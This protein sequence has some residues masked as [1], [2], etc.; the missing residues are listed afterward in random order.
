M[1]TTFDNIPLIRGDSYEWR[2]VFT[3]KVEENGETI[4]RPLDISRKTLTFTIKSNPDD[5]D[6]EALCQAHT[7]FPDD[8]NSRNG[9][10]WLFVPHDATEGLPVI[11]GRLKPTEGFVYYDF[12]LSYLDTLGRTIVKTLEHGTKRPVFDT[13]RTVF[14]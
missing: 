2:V 9:I 6:A 3:E 11:T 14:F 13:T 4:Q 12:Q 1:T 5:T 7:V 10:G 8:E